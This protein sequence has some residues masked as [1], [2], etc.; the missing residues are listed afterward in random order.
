ML[1][2]PIKKKWFDMILLGEKKEEYLEIKPFWARRL[3]NVFL[4]NPFC[5]CCQSDIQGE[6][7]FRMVTV[8]LLPRSLQSVR[9][10]WAQARKNG[11]QKK[12]KSILS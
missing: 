4:F 6:I 7:M 5:S 10:L 12:G 9:F 8:K 2:L 3:Y 1:T 11:E